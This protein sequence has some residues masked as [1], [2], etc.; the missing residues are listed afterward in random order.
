MESDHRAELNGRAAIE[1][2]RPHNFFAPIR[3]L[4]RDHLHNGDEVGDFKCATCHKD[5]TQEVLEAR[6]NEG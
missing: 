3:D 4:S 1:M 5:I 2:A 6:R